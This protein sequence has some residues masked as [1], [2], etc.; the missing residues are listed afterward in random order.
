[1][2]K[3]ISSNDILANADETMN[4]LDLFLSQFEE[5]SGEGEPS[6]EKIAE[7]ARKAP[8]PEVID[9]EQI[10]IIDHHLYIESV[11][12]KQV[13]KGVLI[14]LRNNT[15][16]TIGKTVIS[17]IF[18]DKKGDVLD[19][20]I[21]NIKDIGSSEIFKAVVYP[22]KDIV[23]PI[24]SYCVEVIE[25]VMTPVPIVNGNN[26]IEILNH[27]FIYGD[28]TFGC[29]NIGGGICISI[30]NVSNITV[31]EALFEAITYDSEGNILERLKHKEME[32]NPDDSRAITI[33]IDNRKC[34]Y[35]KSYKVNLI[36]T[37]TVDI[38]K[39]QLRQ[40]EMRTIESNIKEITGAIK[41]ISVNKA[42]AAVIATFYN[43]SKEEIGKK[44]LQIKGIEPSSVKKFSLTF[45]C[46][47]NS[48]KTYALDIG[49]IIH[50]EFID[51][52]C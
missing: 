33:R 17:M 32:I 12:G 52:T 22:S 14:K 6:P 1:M 44:V 8:D 37:I 38:E 3:R 21:R 7:L 41:N 23:R 51:I 24:Q 40:N 35:V 45:D 27:Y 10:E 48:I 28:N 49:E 34:Y 25:V 36:K 47:E 11:A 19:E 16:S 5:T 46:A 26:L 20:C 42:D 39:F 43:A 4:E 30:K 31:A 13:V 2:S 29:G 15:T 50:G 18:Y 9:N